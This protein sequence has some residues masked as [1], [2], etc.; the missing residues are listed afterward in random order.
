M[1]KESIAGGNLKTVLT[2][3]E[4]D[5]PEHGEAYKVVKNRKDQIPPFVMIGN[6]FKLKGDRA[7]ESIDFISVFVN[8]IKSR[9]QKIFLML[10]KSM[11]AVNLKDVSVSIRVCRTNESLHNML[12]ISKSNFS[13]GLKEL[14][15]ADIVRKIEKDMYLFNPAMIIPAGKA[16]EATVKLWNKLENKSIKEVQNEES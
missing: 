13:Q 10:I 14:Y 2:T 1:N 5:P 11:V 16:Y 4:D 6:G 3:I 9:G 15:N 8:N 7:L 12:G